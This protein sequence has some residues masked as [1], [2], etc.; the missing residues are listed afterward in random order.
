MVAPKNRASQYS[1]RP[2][3]Q[4]SIG[5][6][7]ITYTNNA[8]VHNGDKKKRDRFWQVR[9][10]KGPERAS[11]AFPRSGSEVR[12][13]IGQFSGLPARKPHER[14]PVVDSRCHKRQDNS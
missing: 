7:V 9:G 12:A 10:G 6:S 1:I 2:E 11:Q 13:L 14:L 8:E 5:Y 3:I 4:Q